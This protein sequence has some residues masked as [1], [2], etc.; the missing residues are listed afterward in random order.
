MAEHSVYR[1]YGLAI[2][3]AIA[4]PLPLAGKQDGADLRLVYPGRS[5][6][7]LPASE[8]GGRELAIDDRGW[9]LRFHRMT[10]DWILFRYCRASR[11]L[12]VAG[13]D[14]WDDIIPILLGVA[15]GVLLRDRGICVFHGS[16]VAH[17]G[18][19]V[20]VLG[21]S[22]AG[23]STLVGA[24]MARGAR[25]VTD[26]LIVPERFAGGFAVQAGHRRLSLEPDAADVLPING[27]P[28]I[29][30]PSRSRGSKLWIDADAF[31]GGFAADPARLSA[32]Y[33]LEPR[34]LPQTRPEVILLPARSAAVELMKQVYGVNW[35]GQP[36]AELLRRCT[37]VAS[38]VPVARL[39]RPDALA[40]LADTAELL[41]AA[42]SVTAA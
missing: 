33:V 1:L 21:P 39:R 38:R 40:A 36:T 15:A 23:K 14:A 13:T 2:E 37:E 7:H 25:L 20:A 4:L 29:L 6:N 28:S 16:T 35:I 3:S 5:S 12:V 31:P 17:H 27:T 24:L 32:I 18:R 10:G 9:Q 26:D 34:D 30:F 22:G 8:R 19:A 11:Q 42:A 41:L